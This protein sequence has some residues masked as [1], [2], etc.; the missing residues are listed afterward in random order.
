MPTYTYYCEECGS[1]QEILH[2][3]GAPKRYK[4]C[5][6]VMQRRFPSPNLVT[7]TT[8]MANRKDG[9]EHMPS[10]RKQAYA[11]ARAA[12]V[13]PTGKVYCS[14]LCP[15]GES[16]SPKAWISSKDD[17]RKRIREMGATSESLGV[18][19]PAPSAPK[20]YR[21]ADSIVQGEVEKIVAR[22]GGDLSSR[23]RRTLVNDTR[24]RLS[25]NPG[26]V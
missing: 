17:A 2:A 13:N 15:L 9:L 8:F 5:D 21:V 4:C 3:A 19:G 23:E 20:P 7:D 25:P 6:T 10:M 1:E 14:G 16:L 11:K 22:R 24:E 12:G 26:A 18:K